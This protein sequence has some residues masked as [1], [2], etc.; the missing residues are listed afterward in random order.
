MSLLEQISES[1]SFAEGMKLDRQIRKAHLVDSSFTKIRVAIL[2]NA[3]VD[4]LSVFVRLFLI[5]YGFD[6]DIWISEFDVIDQYLLDRNSELHRFR[7]DVVWFFTDERLLCKPDAVSSPDELVSRLKGLWAIS[8]N[9]LGALVIQNNLVRPVERVFGNFEPSVKGSRADV[10]LACNA[11]LAGAAIGGVTILDLE[12]LSCLY[13]KLTW[14]DD[15]MWHIAKTPFDLDFC[16][17][18]A[19]QVADIIASKRGLAKKVLV[20]DLDNTLWGGVI[21]DDGLG[22]IKVGYGAD[23][24]AYSTFQHY[25]LALK[26][27]GVVLAVCSK[28]DEA[29]A[30]LPFEQHAEMVLRLDDISEFRANWDHKV[31]NIVKIAERLNLGLDSFVFVDD[32]PAERQLVR[33]NLPMVSVPELPVDPSLYVRCLDRHG[34]FETISFSEEDAQRSAKYRENSARIALQ[35][36][37]VDL[38]DYLR[39]LEMS[40]IVAGVNGDTIARASQLICKSNQFHLTTTRYSPEERSLHMPHR[41]SSSAT[42]MG[43][44]PQGLA[45]IQSRP[46]RNLR[47]GRDD[48]LSPGQRGEAR[49]RHQCW[50]APQPEQERRLGNPHREARARDLCRQ[51]AFERSNCT[52]GVA[53]IEEG[54]DAP[55]L[56]WQRRPWRAGECARTLCRTQAVHRFHHPQLMDRQIPERQALRLQAT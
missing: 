1:I 48:D 42:A 43:A 38:G 25:L 2:S 20:L 9:E 56:E 30:R 36:T 22:G 5:K 44:R 12:F 28:N 10:V 46:D 54:A 13:G 52:A 14:Q 39:R 23:G 4:Q 41:L 11:L 40:A 49:H 45:G 15:R 6:P 7:P 27:R 51:Y 19:R 32:N 29:N 17:P 16:P 37:A 35:E 18:V 33:D 3:T 21:G 26:K 31:G 8:T 55:R 34:Y 53:R 50:R 47:P 24:E